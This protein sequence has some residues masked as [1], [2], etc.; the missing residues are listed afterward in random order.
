MFNVANPKVLGLR[1]KQKLSIQNRINGCHFKKS[2]LVIILNHKFHGMDIFLKAIPSPVMSGKVTANW[3]SSERTPSSYDCYDLVKIILPF[4]RRSFEILPENYELTSFGIEFELPER[5]METSSRKQL[6]YSCHGELITSLMQ[7]SVLFSCNLLNFSRDGMLVEFT[8]NNN[9]E[10]ALFNEKIPAT[11]TITRGGIT[12]FSGQVDVQHRTGQKFFLKLDDSMRQRITARD[13]RAR[14]LKLTP[15]PILNF[16]HPIT[17]QNHSC[18]LVDLGSIGFSVEEGV[19][20]SVL[21]PGLILV[22]VEIHLG[23]TR[24]IKCTAQ[25]VYTRPAKDRSGYLSSGLAILDAPADE[26]YSLMGIIQQAQDGRAYVGTPVSLDELFEFFFESGFVYPSKYKELIEQKAKFQ[27]SY[28][29]LY[30][31]GASIA[32]H[33]IYRVHGSLQGHISALR[34]YSKSWINHHH[35]GFG[36]HRAGLKALQAISEYQNDSYRLHS[37]DI[38]YI[39]AYYRPENKFP[40]R[41]FG[42]IAKKIND[43]SIVSET[44]FGYFY[45]INKLRCSDDLPD[46]WHISPASRFDIIEFSSYYQSQEESLLINALDLTPEGYQDKIIEQLYNDCGLTRTRKVY[47]IKKAG[48]LTALVD[49]QNSDPG[50]NLSEITNAV[51]FYFMPPE[52]IPLDIFKTISYGL[53]KKYKKWNHPLMIYPFMEDWCHDIAPDK[54]YVLWILEIAKGS[55]TYMDFLYKYVRND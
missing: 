7:N 32:R 11:M 31:E 24:I 49:V 16:S 35:A 29:T 47:A 52:I 38:R 8:T 26:H 54:S 30:Q 53:V 13:H 3:V 36:E 23:S 44:K 14:R 51:T 37:A 40:R 28:R 27:K 12:I 41:F 19:S 10:L 25:V 6:R 50:L 22:G 33:F 2:P 46:E 18:K 5:S 45:N 39:L 9:M 42:E 17:G 15:A 55:D 21:F 43:R 20:T 48:N 4:G 34:A 1:S